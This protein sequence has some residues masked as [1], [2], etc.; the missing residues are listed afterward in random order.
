M[1]EKKRKKKILFRG[2]WY[3]E[4]ITLNELL[5]KIPDDFPEERKESEE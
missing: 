2:K 3:P 5:K 1:E 4:D